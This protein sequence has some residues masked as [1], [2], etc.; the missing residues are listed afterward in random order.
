MAELSGTDPAIYRSYLAALE[1]PAKTPAAAAALESSRAYGTGGNASYLARLGAVDGTLA[2][3]E[4]AHEAYDPG[5]H[6]VN[7]LPQYEGLR[8]DPRFRAFLKKLNLE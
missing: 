1:D 8:A 7:A 6:W 4:G 3:L 2:W 5:L